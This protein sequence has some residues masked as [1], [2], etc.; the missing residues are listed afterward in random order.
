MTPELERVGRLM[1]T[2]QKNTCPTSAI[3]YCFH[4][5]VTFD[6]G[7][8]W[9]CPVLNYLHIDAP[10]LLPWIPTLVRSSAPSQRGGSLQGVPRGRGGAVCP[11]GVRGGSLQG[12]PRGRGGVVRP[13]GVRGCGLDRW[14]RVN[15]IF[16]PAVSFSANVI[17]DFLYISSYSII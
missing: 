16:K 2:T 4:A 9:W 11:P 3:R 13:P 14:I 8:R 1:K 5:P 7:V 15:G 6:C 12:V 17:Y 10:T